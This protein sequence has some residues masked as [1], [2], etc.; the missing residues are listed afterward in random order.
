[1]LCSKKRM[2]QGMGG[3]GVT[4]FLYIERVLIQLQQSAAKSINVQQS[5]AKCKP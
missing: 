3:N 4:N 2:T 1:M 5:A